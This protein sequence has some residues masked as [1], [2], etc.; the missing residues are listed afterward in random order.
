MARLSYDTAETLVYDP[1]AG[2]RTAT[3]AALYN[4]GFRRIETVGSLEAVIE[5]IRRRPPDLVVCESQGA[6]NELCALIQSLR[7][8]STGYNPFIVIIVTAWEQNSALVTRVLNSGADDLLLRPFSTAMLG[9]RIQA[10]I[11]RRKGFVITS[12]YVGPD[13]RKDSVRPSNVEL[14]EPPNSL[15]MKAQERLTS[16]EAAQRLDAE[17][18]EA[19][20]ILN[21]EK[22]RRDAFQI[23][24]L[25]RLTQEHVPNS[26]KYTFDLAKLCEVT[27]G[28]AR[29]CMGTEFEP[30]FEWCDSILAAIEGLEAGVD[31]NASM[32]LLGHA[33]LNLNQ[34][35]S[36]EKSAAEHLSAIDATVAIVKARIQ[37]AMAS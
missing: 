9:Q 16:E 2:N 31:R 7:Q 5:C 27:R 12:E 33:A 6:E 19:R 14:F 8:G 34:I 35:F 10:H 32:H 24:V 26:G 37:P 18:K 29:R 3:R 36:P 1:V 17:L 15:K 11:E 25:W 13:R 28:V 22:L 23:C 4:L 30:A 20:E 21:I